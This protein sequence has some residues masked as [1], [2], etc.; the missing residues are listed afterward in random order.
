MKTRM[1]CIVNQYISG[2]HA[3]IQSAHAIV[4]LI[5]K[6]DHPAKTSEE[7]AAHHLLKC[8]KEI[9]KTIIVL[10]GGYQSVLQDFLE[11][12]KSLQT[13]PV[14][15]WCEEKKAL[16]GAMTAV[17]VVL[18]EFIYNPEYRPAPEGAFI[19]PHAME[20]NDTYTCEETGFVHTYTPAEKDF[21]KTLKSFKLK[22]E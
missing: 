6:Y 19:P 13:Y 21:I 15:G 8:W 22:G 16:N 4:E 17:A 10:N 20:V 7:F 1:Y 18:P 11:Q 3:G 12:A 5:E 14:A 2:I 9:D